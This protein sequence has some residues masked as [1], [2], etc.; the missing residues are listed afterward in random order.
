MDFRARSIHSTYRLIRGRLRIRPIFGALAKPTWVSAQW[1]SG[2]NCGGTAQTWQI[3]FLRLTS[4]I[5]LKS[6]PLWISARD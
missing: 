1:K 5:A 2:S 6:V 4:W 3:H